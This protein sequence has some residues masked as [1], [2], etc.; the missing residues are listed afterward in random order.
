M[1]FKMKK[2]MVMP[3]MLVFIILAVIGL[4]VILAGG[5]PKLWELFGISGKLSACNTQTQ[6]CSCLLYSDGGDKLKS[7]PSGTISSDYSDQCPRTCTREN[8]EEQ[9]KAAEKAEKE[10]SSKFEVYGHCCRGDFEDWELE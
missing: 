2:A 6:K 5:V 7:C 3:A 9:L 10:G 8:F 4:V 1:L